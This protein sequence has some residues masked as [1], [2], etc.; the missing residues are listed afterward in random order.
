MPYTR[1]FPTYEPVQWDGT[2]AEEILS[3]ADAWFSCWPDQHATRDPESDVITTC[4]GYQL[5]LGDWLVPAGSWG[6]PE[7]G[8]EG[9][10]EV[11]Q[12]VVFQVKYAQQA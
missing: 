4:N 12:D 2:N 3:K 6:V 11:V 1:N 10:P 8:P 7:A 9:S 5:S